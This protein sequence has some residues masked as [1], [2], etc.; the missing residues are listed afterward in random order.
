MNVHFRNATIV[1]KKS[2]R[3]KARRD[4]YNHTVEPHLGND[5]L[6]F[7]RNVNA[8]NNYGCITIT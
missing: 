8:C 7:D 2:I 6:Y 1:R 4:F 3:I 5:L